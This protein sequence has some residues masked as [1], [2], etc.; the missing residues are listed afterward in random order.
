VIEDQVLRRLHRAAVLA[1]RPGVSIPSLDVPRA[2]DGA[3]T[4]EAIRRLVADGRAV[5]VRRDLFVL[6]DATGLSPITLPDLIDAVAPSPY[7]I[8]GGRALQQHA[9][10][11]QHFFTVVVLVAS[12]VAGFAYRGERA[13]FAVTRPERVWGW[14][15]EPGPRF[16]LPER[17]IMDAF[18]HP[19][20]GVSFSQAIGALRTAQRTIPAFLDRLAGAAR[21]YGSAATCRRVGF[22]VERLYGTEASEPFLPL[23]GTSPTP[24]L[25][26]P[27]G[28]VEGPVERPWHVL[29]NV[30]P[31]FAI[32]GVT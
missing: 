11:D 6:P 13:N 5:P 18:N 26:R 9:L 23:I 16:A 8:T 24:T 30:D 31:E 21:R 19:R 10:T 2:T 25:L 12:R 17:A 7:L 22:V 15:D 14:S 29:V 28:P 27:G 1:G 4:T 3:S 32:E 20:Y